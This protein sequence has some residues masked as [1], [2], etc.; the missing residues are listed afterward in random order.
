MD[1][2]VRLNPFA[3]T[4]QSRASAAT[5]K[6][7]AKRKDKVKKNREFVKQLLTPSIAPVRG[8]EEYAPF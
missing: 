8:E 5:Q 4:R 1:A 6:S 2:M 7:A 3:L